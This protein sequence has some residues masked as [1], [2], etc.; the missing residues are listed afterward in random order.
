MATPYKQ[1]TQNATPGGPMVPIAMVG[2]I[3]AVLKT[4][5]F[6]SAYQML[7]ED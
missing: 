7:L 4:P 5:R 6:F 3:G 1:G 2:Q